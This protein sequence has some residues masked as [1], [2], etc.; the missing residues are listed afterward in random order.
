MG[1]RIRALRLGLAPL[2]APLRAGPRACAA[3]SA[4][5]CRRR[6]RSACSGGPTSSSSTTTPTSRCW[7]TST[8]SVLGRPGREVWPEI[9]DVLGPLLKGVIDTG[10]GVSRLGPPFYLFRH[11]FAEETYFDVSYDP[12]RDET[13][14][15]RRRVLHR[16]RDHRPRAQRA[17]AAHAA[18]PGARQGKPF[19]R[20]GVPPGAACSGGQRPGRPVREPLSPRR[21]WQGRALLRL[22]RRAGRRRAEPGRGRARATPRWPFAA[23]AR[24]GQPLVQRVASRRARARAARRRGAGTD[25]D[26]PDLA[27]AAGAPASSSPGRAVSSCSRS[28]L[29]R[30]LRSHRRPD[31][32]RGEPG[33]LVRGGTQARR[34]PGRARPRQDDVLQQHQPRV[35]HAADPDARARSTICWSRAGALERGRSR[36]ARP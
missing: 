25:L 31:R 7:A 15:G 29:S 2:S 9:W 20:G 26:P 17:P 30:L 11:G 34:G 35:P 13:R 27:R 32:D 33:V 1:E 18:R 19:G 8:G 36:D 14:P 5:C 22:R 16:H 23:I 24:D 10:R 21:R 28:K 6:R 3:P 12:V 4:S